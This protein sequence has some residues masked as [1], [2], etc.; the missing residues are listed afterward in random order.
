MQTIHQQQLK[1]RGLSELGNA[2]GQQ[3]FDGRDEVQAAAVAAEE[4]GGDDDCG[5]LGAM[6]S[7]P[8]RP[9]MVTFLDEVQGPPERV[10]LA[11]VE[12]FNQ[13]QKTLRS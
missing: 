5:P 12:L 3:R 9:R 7:P 13:M 10:R 11:P 8:P 2:R 4:L 6:V 1:A